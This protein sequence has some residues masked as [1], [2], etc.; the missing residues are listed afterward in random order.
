MA[1]HDHH[2][3]GVDAQP[4][5]DALCADLVHDGELDAPVV[6]GFIE[7]LAELVPDVRTIVDLGSGPGV[8]ACRLAEAFPQAHVVA[9]DGSAALLELARQRTVRLGLTQRVITRVAALPDEIPTLPAADVIWASGLVHHLPDPHH[10]L[11]QI[12]AL[13]RPGGVLAIREGGLPLRF[14]PEGVA[15]GLLARVEATCD[16]LLTEGHSPFGI[17]SP[18]AAW[19][20]VMRASGLTH[21]GSRSFLFERPA[22]LSTADREWLRRRLA[23]LGEVAD[24]RLSAADR[25]AIAQLVDQAA[26]DGISNRDDFFVLGASTVHV[27][28]SA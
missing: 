8:A 27:A 20:D 14:L 1:H 7:W 6:I 15:P 22:P 4:D 19:P 11:G 17:V 28:A 26:P 16:E 5:W 21:R 23:R 13:L 10:A 25:A 12:G 2:S 9:V 24:E 18:G 3:D